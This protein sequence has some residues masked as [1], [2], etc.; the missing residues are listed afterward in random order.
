MLS[1]ELPP[2]NK[3]RGCGSPMLAVI[4]S[5]HSL[6]AAGEYSSHLSD[7]GAPGDSD[8]CIHGH[9][10]PPHLQPHPAAPTLPPR[11]LQAFS[12][13]GPTVISWLV[14]ILR[15][16]LLISSG[17]LTATTHLPSLTLSSLP[18]WVCHLIFPCSLTGFPRAGLVGTSVLHYLL[19]L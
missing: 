13:L 12:S 9:P 19:D 18:Q 3:G 8:P 5:T 10:L 16:H 1:W 14:H 17:Q 15:W 11:D 6:P 4:T 7:S 2:P